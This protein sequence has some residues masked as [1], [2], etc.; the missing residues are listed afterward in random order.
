MIARTAPPESSPEELL[1]RFREGGDVEALGALFDG[2]SPT[3]FRLALALAPDAAAAEDAVQETFLTLMA[4]SAGYDASR[5]LVPWLVGVLRLKVHEARRRVRRTVDP[6]RLPPPLF[7]EDP[8][9]AAESGEEVARVRE[10]IEE[11]P[12]P[13]RAVAVM[14]WRYGLEPSAI[15]DVRGEPPGTVRSLLHRARERLRDRLRVLP[16]FV[17][18]PRPPRG[19]EAVRAVVLERGGAIAGAAAA[20]AAASSPAL[21]S[22]GLAGGVLMSAKVVTACV[23][24]VVLSGVAWLALRPPGPPAAPPPAPR[25]PDPRDAAPAVSPPTPA[26]PPPRPV[27]ADLPPPVDLDACDRDLDLFGTT[28]D[29]A[30]APVAGARVE[31]VRYP[32]RRSGLGGVDL[33]YAEEA[34]PSTRSA[35]DGTFSIR[36][37]RGETVDL[38]AT[39]EGL[40]QGDLTQ[41]L[42]GER[43][44]LVLRRGGATVRV[45]VRDEGGRAVEGARLRF[46]T[47]SPD[48]VYGRLILA[49]TGTTDGD[50]RCDFPNLP[51]GKATLSVDHAT[52][53]QPDWIQ[54]DVPADG[55]LDI[56]V[57]LPAGRTVRGRVVDAMSGKPLPGARVGSNW[58][59]DRPVTAD[60]EGRYEFPGW[61][62]RGTSILTAA[63]EGYA[64]EWRRV[65]G[66]GD[67]D[68][69]LEPAFAVSGRVVAV[70]GTPVPGARATAGG[71][72]EDGERSGSTRGGASA[73]G[74]GR[75]VLTGL[76]RRARHDLV[77]EAPGHGRT[78]LSVDA[79]ADGRRERDLGDLP[80]GPARAIE[81]RALDPRGNPLVGADV[82]LARLRPE[83]DP[84]WSE[85]GGRGG[86][87]AGMGEVRRTD[88]LGRFRFPDLSPGRWGLKLVVPG[89]PI[90]ERTLVLTAD[91]DV[92]DVVL[93]ERGSSIVLLVT[94]PDGGPLADI[95]VMSH[96]TFPHP[97]SGVQGTTNLQG[98]TDAAGRVEFRGLPDPPQESP[99]Y[100]FTVQ[101]YLGESAPPW[102]GHQTAPIAPGGPDV[103]VTLRPVAWIRGKVLGPQDEPVPGLYLAAESADGAPL[104]GALAACDAAGEFAMRVPAGATVTLRATGYRSVDVGGGRSTVADT[105]YRAELA[106]VTAPAAGVVVRATRPATDRALGVLVLGVDGRPVADF[107]ISARRAVSG[108]QR[109]AR[110]DGGGRVRWEEMT[111]APWT[112]L[113]DL[114]PPDGMPGDVVPPARVEVVP[115]GQEVVLRFR[116]GRAVEGIVLRPDGTPAP[117]ALLHFNMEDGG[118]AT[119]R[120]P[121]AGE[122]GRFRVL[123]GEGDALRLGA[124]WTDAS[125]NTFSGETGVLRVGESPPVEIRLAAAEGE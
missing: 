101:C 28:V 51:P 29:D 10:A 33:H 116:R 1:A 50:G 52:L 107:G 104:G 60:A 69:A 88:D 25:A 114:R 81:G 68:I 109:T 115:A 122:D 95:G 76:S 44:T 15:A 6:A 11:L 57:V 77:V 99:G 105:G 106:G 63:A 45:T 67:L 98:V 59:M 62:G 5:P 34:G 85:P 17:A 118:G 54:R 84:A 2:V 27:S 96:A 31:T 56:E 26:P 22:L 38:R 92:L 89:A 124:A 93:A 73:D 46:R 65:P 79:P 48:S 55:R 16:A 111:D 78:A 70:D 64:S 112:L 30:G 37:A 91:G 12:E 103:R 8:S 72:W 80:L 83:G 7:P 75:F 119:T 9:A 14:R 74:E 19:M 100:V 35:M 110:T 41:C 42:A 58:V 39:A 40:G 82:N 121:R 97:T 66:E 113:P 87:V 90:V 120:P 102:A 49:R 32:W 21:P 18:G 24:A 23:A 94:D 86:A 117:G 123:F 53:G 3:L 4:G 61:T 108:E 20:A 36:L 47:R 71:H 43:V 13:Y 125:G